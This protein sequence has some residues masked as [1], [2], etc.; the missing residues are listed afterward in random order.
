MKIIDI[1]ATLPGCRV[2]PGD[3]IPRADKIRT[4]AH[5]GCDLTELYMCA[6]SG[7]HAD[8]P[9]HFIENG[10]SADRIALEK[11][12]GSCIV[13]DKPSEARS[14]VSAGVTRILLKGGDITAAQA[15]EL[16]G[17][18]ALIGT[19]GLSFG[20]KTDEQSDVHKIL[21]GEGVVLLEGLCLDDVP[22]GKYM[23]VALPLKI[24]G[25]DGSPVRAV[26]IDE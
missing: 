4:I 8:A 9:S 12:I 1:S 24:A 17:N 13:T 14:L 21:L 23:L 11:C 7:T 2:Y 26:L 20:E 22:C 5:D 3:P 16:A 25:S 6:H 10:E 15:A 18:I 19:D